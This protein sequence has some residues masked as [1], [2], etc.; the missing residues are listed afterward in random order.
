MAGGVPTAAEASAVAEAAQIVSVPVEAAIAASTVAAETAATKMAP[1]TTTAPAD[2]GAEAGAAPPTPTLE[3]TTL[4]FDL[5]PPLQLAREAVRRFPLS[6]YANAAAHALTL[7]DPRPVFARAFADE[8]L[9]G[10][11]RYYSAILAGAGPNIGAALRAL[12]KPNA[13]PALVHCAHGK[14]RSGVFVLLIL[15]LCGVQDDAI[16]ADFAKSEV[17]LRRFREELALA[18]SG[19]RPPSPPSSTAPPAP[20]VPSLHRELGEED[21]R[22]WPIPLSDAI[23]AA[24]ADVAL[25]MLRELRER[26]GGAEAYL[27]RKGRMTREEIA[28]LKRVLTE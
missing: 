8:R 26:Y 24:Q 2:N 16:A 7:R 25:A 15:S 14:D 17:E 5:L 21:E 13:L 6:V 28:A 4:M 12:I 3:E 9:V 11:Q 23:I 10:F 27:L 18:R 1:M 20:S 19:G 22:D